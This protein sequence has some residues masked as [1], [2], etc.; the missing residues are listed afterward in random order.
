MKHSYF[1]YFIGIYEVLMIKRVKL[2]DI[3]AKAG[4]SKMTVSLALRDDASISE[5]TSRK[6][7]KIA[8]ELGYMPNRIAQRLSSGKT[9]TIAVIVGGSFHDDYHN[10]F[11]RGAIPYAMDKDYILTIG[12]AEHSVKLERDLINNYLKNMV[13]GF[14]AFHCNC[15]DNYDIIK[16]SGVPFVLYTKYFENLDS[17]YVVC[18]DYLGAYNMTKYLINQGHNRIGFIYDVGIRQSSE[19]VNR[20]KGYQ[21]AGEESGFQFDDLL[22]PFEC[23]MKSMGKIYDN[24]ELVKSL[25]NANR[26]TA[27]FACNDITASALYLFL[28]SLG[29]RIP[30][31]ISI[32]GYEGVY[33]GEVLRPRLTTVATPIQELGRTAC[34]LLIDKI[35]GNK[36]QNEFCRIKLDPVLTIRNSVLR[37]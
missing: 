23:D 7:K 9:N 31:D 17:D 10:Q 14:L 15:S 36:P 6:I 18:N 34:E 28:E 32:C 13:D 24:D 22:I 2:D 19:V 27:L 11:L 1:R 35:H 21:K 5:N 33:I 25:H 30:E 26:P 37:R 16:R 12:L 8:E 29:L 4:V 3:A 20:I